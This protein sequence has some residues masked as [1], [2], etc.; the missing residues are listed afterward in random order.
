MPDYTAWEPCRYDD[1]PGEKRLRRPMLAN[2]RHADVTSLSTLEPFF[3]RVSW[4]TY[5]GVYSGFG[6]DHEAV[7]K[8]IELDMT[9]TMV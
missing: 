7:E 8:S 5:E 4:M 9:D 2:L 1:G 3:E 6:V